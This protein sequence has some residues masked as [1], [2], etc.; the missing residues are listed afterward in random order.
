MSEDGILRLV[1]VWQ[2]GVVVSCFGKL[3][4][5][6][7]QLLANESEG[8]LDALGLLFE[9]LL[10][11]SSFIRSFPV[12]HLDLTC[13]QLLLRLH[14]IACLGLDESQALFELLGLDHEKAILFLLVKAD[15]LI[16]LQRV[17]LE[18]LLTKMQL[19][20]SQLP[21]ELTSFFRLLKSLTS[22]MLK[23][24]FKTRNTTLRNQLG[25]VGIDILP[26]LFSNCIKVGP[27]LS[28]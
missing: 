2:R 17:E 11:L 5:D 4:L 15:L 13:L 8:C 7:L 28:L 18:L 27:L 24:T 9:L 21:L 3:T 25:L 26:P 20:L 16:I 10:L 22:L 12:D 23:L 1:G 6:K 19:G 14:E